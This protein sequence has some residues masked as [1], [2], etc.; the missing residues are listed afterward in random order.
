[1][2][3]LIAKHDEATLCERIDTTLERH[4][5]GDDAGVH[6][7][8]VGSD[9]GLLNLGRD[10]PRALKHLRVIKRVRIEDRGPRLSCAERESLE[11]I[12]GGAELS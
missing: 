10:G 1:M 7:R 8:E 2:E 3:F 9:R 4:I 5:R 12:F 11:V 6:W